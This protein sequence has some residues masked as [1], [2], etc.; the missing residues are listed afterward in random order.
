MCVDKMVVICCENV[1]E[2]DMCI[3]SDKI[4]WNP[5]NLVVFFYGGLI[6]TYFRVDSLAVNET[7]ILFHISHNAPVLHPIMHHF[8]PE[9]C[10]QFYKKM[11][12]C[13]YLSNALWDVCLGTSE[14]I[15]KNM[16][17]MCHTNPLEVMIQNHNKTRHS[18]IACIFRGI[19]CST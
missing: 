17:K 10:A 2:N 3:F 8:A 14:G 7:I 9:I 19:Y 11:V 13:G 6:P 16:G 4:V 1:I 12:H 5:E 15:L 18:E